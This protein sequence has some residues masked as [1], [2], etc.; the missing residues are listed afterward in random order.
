MKT[1]IQLVAILAMGWMAQAFAGQSARLV[2]MERDASKT[3]DCLKL[4]IQVVV[5]NDRDAGKQGVNGV[6]ALLDNG[7][8]AYWTEMGGWAPYSDDNLIKPVMPGLKKLDVMGEYEVFSG[9]RDALCK[10]SDGH[11]FNLYAWHAALSKTE[12]QKV[13]ATI[14][15]YAI[16][17]WQA[18]NYWNSALLYMALSK[19][20]AGLVHSVDCNK[21]S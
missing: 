21:K 19:Q 4:K 7:L 14:S 1:L 6:F 11:S 17:G 2:C 18:E 13:Q 8:V 10:L 20:Q 3:Q 5:K 15:R 16:E 9:N 12:I